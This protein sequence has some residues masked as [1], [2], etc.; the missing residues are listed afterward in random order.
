MFGIITGGLKQSLYILF[1]ETPRVYC[2]ADLVLSRAVWLYILLPQ[3]RFSRKSIG[4][5]ICKGRLEHGTYNTLFI[6]CVN[7]LR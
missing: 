7:V 1:V 5:S 6:L 2:Q 4:F 3:S